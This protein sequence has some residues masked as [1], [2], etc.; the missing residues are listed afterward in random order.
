MLRK[1]M[2][3][4]FVLVTIEAFS[5]PSANHKN[6]TIESNTIVYRLPMH[7]APIHYDL[8]LE[9]GIM[10]GD[11]NFIGE[12]DIKIEVREPSKL[13]VLNWKNL[14]INET[15]SRLDK[16]NGESVSPSEHHYDPYREMLTLIFD[17]IIDSAVYT[18]HL[19]FSDVLS[20]DLNGF[21][22]SSYIN[23]N[24]DTT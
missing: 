5:L 17:K 10:V 13:I 15:Q 16:D 21:F 12:T 18:L 8:K 7:I 24:G 3:L 11:F 9:S 6:V 23:E 4:F 22:R 20:T 14:T 2:K 1:L 19:E